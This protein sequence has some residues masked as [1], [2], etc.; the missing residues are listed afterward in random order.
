MLFAQLKER[1]GKLLE[2]EAFLAA[3]YL[4]PRISLV[5]TNNKKHLAKQNLKQTA[6]RIYQLKQLSKQ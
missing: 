5:L 4:D 6:F 2:N 3:I 1:E